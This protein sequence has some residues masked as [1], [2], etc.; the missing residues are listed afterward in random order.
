MKIPRKN[1]SKRKAKQE[2]RQLGA[3]KSRKNIKSD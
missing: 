2:K 1:N 3:E